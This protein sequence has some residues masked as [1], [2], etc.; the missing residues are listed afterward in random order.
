[1][2]N[3]RQILGGTIGGFFAFAAQNRC[4]RLFARETEAAA[5]AKRCIVLW[6]NGGP[7]QLDTFDPKPGQSTGGEFGSIPTSSSEIRISETLP[8][9]AGQMDA[10][11]IVR[12]LTSPVG[13]HQQARYFLHTGY[14]FVSSFPR[15]S[16][17]SV[18]SH[19]GGD[20]AIP[21]Y[22]VRWAR[23]VTG[24]PIWGP[25]MRRFPLRMRTGLASC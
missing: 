6:M 25:I 12:N 4:D 20:S 5:K 3:R 16:L 15:P 18:I 10:L 14:Q 8:L 7:S 9:I 13:D 2:M 23:P 19:A 11:S 1:M 22:V 24:Q 17:G 21:N